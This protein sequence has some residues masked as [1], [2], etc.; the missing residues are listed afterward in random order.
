MTKAAGMVSDSWWQC[1][2]TDHCTHSSNYCALF[3][4]AYRNKELF[5]CCQIIRTAAHSDFVS[6][7]LFVTYT[8]VFSSRTYKVLIYRIITYV[9][10][11][12]MAKHLSPI[13][14]MNFGQ[15]S[16]RKLWSSS[17][18]HCKFH[19]TEEEKQTQLL[20]SEETHSEFCWCELKLCQDSGIPSPYPFKHSY[21][22]SAPR[23]AVSSTF[24][25]SAPFLS[26]VEVAQ[27]LY[28]CFIFKAVPHFHKRKYSK[29]SFKKVYYIS[30]SANSI[31]FQQSHIIFLSSFI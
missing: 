17:V 10:K 8:R 5:S 18:P 20:L 16:E 30:E 6:H 23:G 11:Y 2:S 7:L 31:Y 26:T 29:W 1:Y 22:C 14:T 12:I 25:F 27:L 4:I 9:F 3:R 28:F 19:Y 21:P 15:Q 13:Y 24:L